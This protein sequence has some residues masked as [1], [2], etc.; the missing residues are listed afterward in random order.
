M[1]FGR[2]IS[3]GDIRPEYENLEGVKKADVTGAKVRAGAGQRSQ[4]HKI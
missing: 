2:T 4:L 1:A 3:H